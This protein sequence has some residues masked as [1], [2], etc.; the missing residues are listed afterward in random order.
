MSSLW[1]SVEN[2]CHVYR[3]HSCTACLVLY[4]LGFRRTGDFS[5]GSAAVYV[6]K[7]YG[8]SRSRR[9]RWSAAVRPVT[10]SPVPFSPFLQRRTQRQTELTSMTPAPRTLL[11]LRLYRM[12]P[13]AVTT[14]VTTLCLDRPPFCTDT[15]LN[16][17]YWLEH[18]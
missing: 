7:A 17:R 15:V 5:E 6:M 11:K 18:R 2:D 12:V 9:S 3:K 16:A 8:G 1:K 4:S 10:L 14:S 13:S